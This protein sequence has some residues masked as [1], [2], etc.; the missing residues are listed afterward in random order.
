MVFIQS[1]EYTDAFGK[2]SKNVLCLEGQTDYKLS[3]N[4]E[5]N[6]YEVRII[7]GD[8]EK[9]IFT[10]DTEKDCTKILQNIFNHHASKDPSTIYDVNAFMIPE[11]EQETTL[12]EIEDMMASLLEF[13]GYKG[14]VEAWETKLAEDYTESLVEADETSPLKVN[15]AGEL[16]VDP[17]SNILHPITAYDKPDMLTAHTT[18]HR[19]IH[20]NWRFYINATK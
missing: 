10:A 2:K 7:I 14:L 15:D 13:H 20:Y 8:Y 18:E 4:E 12:E 6:K 5:S 1:Q 16:L 11:V 19:Y 9:Y 3:L 17:P